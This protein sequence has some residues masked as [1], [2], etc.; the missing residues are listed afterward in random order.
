MRISPN[1]EKIKLEKKLEAELLSLEFD[2][3][4]LW[5]M[6]RVGVLNYL[7]KPNLFIKEVKKKS[8]NSFRSKILKEL[9]IL[10][11]FIFSILLFKIRNQKTIIF[12]NT[13]SIKNVLSNGKIILKNENLQ[14]LYDQKK[15]IIYVNSMAGWTVQ[16]KKIIYIPAISIGIYIKL[17]SLFIPKIDKLDYRNYFNLNKNIFDRYLVD[18]INQYKIWKIILR[19]IRPN[20]IIL[21][22]PHGIFE[23]IVIAAKKNN[24]KTIEIYH[25][26]I[27]KNEFAYYTKNLIFENLIHGFSDEYYCADV[28]DKKYLLSI[29]KLYKNII[30]MSDRRVYK[31]KVNEKL[32]LNSFLNNSKMKRFLI[33]ASIT[34]GD[35][36]D[37]DK[38]LKISRK[39]IQKIY[40]DVKIRL[41]P[42][43][44]AERWAKFFK[45]HPY[46]KMDKNRSLMKSITSCKKILLSSKT[47]EKL[48]IDNKI[49]YEYL[50]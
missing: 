49:N 35:I 26:S 6:I 45:R 37:Y 15:A 9:Y 14:R 30:L 47:V 48:L 17:C 16:S 19:F 23:P 1:I 44:N 31:I 34:D 27:T 21:E 12:I 33:I 10:L 43:D 2:G 32:R 11:L 18:C 36:D 22:S 20:E 46:V 24:I 13:F 29:N 41:H 5:S 28:R 7:I 42:D 8:N 39:K 3:I 50:Q 4:S 38:Y 25:G 40:T